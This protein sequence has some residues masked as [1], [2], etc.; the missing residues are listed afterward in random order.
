ME[1]D[2]LAPLP[3]ATL[4]QSHQLRQW[5]ALW[6]RRAEDVRQESRRLCQHS[7]V[8]QARY[9]EWRQHYFLVECA[10]C[11]KRISWQYMEE[12]LAVLATSHGICLTCLATE[13]RELGLRKS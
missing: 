10:W 6:V 11:A 8:L 13:L 1:T 12:P 5:N 7:R 4:V 9:Q 2:A 3:R